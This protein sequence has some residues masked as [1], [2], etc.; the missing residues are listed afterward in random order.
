MKERTKIL[1]VTLK[2][3]EVETFRAGG[4]GGQHQ[5]K[6]D[7]AVRVRH[8][9]SGAVGES[10]EERSQLANKQKAFGRMARSKEMEVWLRKQVARIT[11][12]EA[13]IADEVE[14]QMRPHNIVVEV[15]EDGK[16]VTM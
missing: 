12:Q 8:R 2:D 14:R 3:C 11:G 5:N 1:S 7:S 13:A 15:K 6:T 10:R 9:P 16:W 4:K